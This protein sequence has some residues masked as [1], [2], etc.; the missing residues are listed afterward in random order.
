MI[1]KN[2]LEAILTKVE[3][4]TAKQKNPY[5]KENLAWATWIIARLGGWQGYRSS[6][7]PPGPICLRRGLQ[8]FLVFMM[9]GY[10][11]KMCV[12][13][14]PTEEVDAPPGA[15]GEGE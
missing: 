10:C 7:G 13:C 6:K 5:P 1:E 3:G 9:V 8:R 4:K 12:H 11:A 15:A 14:S 2:V